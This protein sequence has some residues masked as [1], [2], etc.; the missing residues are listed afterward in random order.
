[1]RSRWLCRRLR[2][3]G[4]W[5]RGRLRRRLLSNLWR[6]EGR[7]RGRGTKTIKRIGKEQG[8]VE[9][10]RRNL[11]CVAAHGSV[12]K[13]AV[14]IEG[15]WG[16]RV[17]FGLGGRLGVRKRSARL[18]VGIDPLPGAIV[19]RDLPVG[20]NSVFCDPLSKCCPVR[21]SKQVLSLSV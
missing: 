9:G 3:N 8:I 11:L 5:D 13:S 10:F 15:R 21:D 12:K 20:F 19:Y 4:L 14:W 17:E 18:G 6:C 7:D 16:R 2:C 1:M